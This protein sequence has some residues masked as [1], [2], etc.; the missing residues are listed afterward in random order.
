M[1]LLIS[2]A[3]ILQRATGQALGQDQALAR[4]AVGGF[5]PLTLRAAP[6]PGRVI[7]VVGRRANGARDSVSDP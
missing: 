4:R 5:Q 1:D 6:Q 7:K 3:S 2:P